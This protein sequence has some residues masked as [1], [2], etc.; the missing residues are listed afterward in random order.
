[1][2]FWDFIWKSQAFWSLEPVSK[3]KLGDS[4]SKAV[5]DS[6]DMDQVVGE[7]GLY[8]RGKK[9]VVVIEDFV[10]ILTEEYHLIN[11]NITQ[12]VQD[13][14][15]SLILQSKQNLAQALQ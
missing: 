10:E 4:L 14:E 15:K 3:E 2:H 9:H 8:V 11:Q 6:L 12:I 7:L 5:Y 1:M 13:V